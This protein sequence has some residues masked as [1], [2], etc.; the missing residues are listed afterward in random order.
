MRNKRNESRLGCLIRRII[1]RT[2]RT[3]IG[4]HS[5]R[6]P[7]PETVSLVDDDDDLMALARALYPE[8]YNTTKGGEQK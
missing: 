4:Q 5:M 2:V 3:T 6:R 7:A 8:R 1:G